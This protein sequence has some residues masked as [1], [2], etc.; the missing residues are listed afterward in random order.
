LRALTL[1]SLDIGG[2][3]IGWFAGE[4]ASSGKLRH[5]DAQLI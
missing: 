5:Y 4:T 2:F 1:H 3:G